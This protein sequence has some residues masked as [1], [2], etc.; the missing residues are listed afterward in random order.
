MEWM[1]W[2]G[3]GPRKLP[4]TVR[5]DLVAQFRIDPDRVAGL[6]YL[7]RRGAFA[8]RPVRLVRIFDPAIGSM[9]LTA[10]KHFEQLEERSVLFEGW[11]E[12]NGTPCLKDV[13]HS[14]H[15]R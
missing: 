13:R 7:E 4:G 5:R 12:M 14:V 11:L 3:P 2:R 8:G 10:I 9:D 1:F 6:R 15:A